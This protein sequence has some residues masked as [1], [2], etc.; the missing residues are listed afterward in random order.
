MRWCR[1][2]FFHPPEAEEAVVFMVVEEGSS[3]RKGEATREDRGL[4]VEA[5]SF[6]G[7][8]A[9]RLRRGCERVDLCG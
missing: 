2:P 5:A 7:F 8:D 9:S 4:K 6:R 3:R 1:V